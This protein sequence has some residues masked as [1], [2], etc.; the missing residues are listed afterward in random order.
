VHGSAL[1]Q[2]P[3][4]QPAGIAARTVRITLD[5]LILGIG[6]QRR[7]AHKVSNINT[8]QRLIPVLGPGSHTA[9]DAAG[10]TRYQDERHAAETDV[11]PHY[12]YWMF[13]RTILRQL[14]GF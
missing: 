6:G 5:E 2:G 3:A 9:T 13:M 10:S 12:R 1:A 4:Q 7:Q 8:S 11:S 14:C